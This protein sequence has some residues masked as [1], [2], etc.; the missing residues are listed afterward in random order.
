MEYP[1]GENAYT[2]GQVKYLCNSCAKNRPIDYI[3]PQLDTSEYYH[4][5]LDDRL[6]VLREIQPEVLN[7]LQKV[8]LFVRVCTCLV[9]NRLQCAN[10]N[11][12]LLYKKYSLP[13]MILSTKNFGSRTSLGMM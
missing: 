9:K 3:A 1:L 4:K 7:K 6:Y 8:Q 5:I 12:S 13:H 2:I 11:V 10:K